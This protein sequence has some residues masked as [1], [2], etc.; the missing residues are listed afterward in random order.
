MKKISL[1][2]LVVVFVSV[3]CNSTT[4]KTTARQQAD[5]TAAE[6]PAAL[7]AIA[8]SSKL[9]IINRKKEKLS[10]GAYR[11]TFEPVSPSMQPT[12]TAK[13]IDGDSNNEIVVDY[14]TGGAHC[15]QVTTILSRTGET[16]M[17]EVLNYTGGTIISG[18]TVSL[19][20]YEA[21]GYFHTCYACG[22]EHPRAV[23]PMANF[24][25]KKGTFGFLPVND[26]TNNAI[27]TNLKFV[28]SRGIPNKDNPGDDGFDDGTR[29]EI[30]INLT[31]WYFNNG[32]NTGE[33]RKLFDEYYSH[34]DGGKIWKD[35]AGYINSFDEDINKALLLK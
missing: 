34:T 1:F 13:D 10:Y 15:C 5:T 12:F 21:L 17:T 35:I 19:D 16:E 14:Y 26:Q 20:F 23:S 22:L 29:K 11:N 3:S 2:P 30:A 9:M 4:D 6:K 18:D 33:T 28:K 32:R 31:A 7:A 25:Y 24:L 8:D 27:L